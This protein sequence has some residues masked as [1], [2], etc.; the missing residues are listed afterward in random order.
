MK[1]IDKII[2]CLMILMLI[3]MVA[4]WSLSAYALYGIYEKDCEIKELNQK[5]E[6]LLDLFTL[7]EGV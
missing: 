6:L 3:T 5:L 4:Y 7:P 1:V 2:K